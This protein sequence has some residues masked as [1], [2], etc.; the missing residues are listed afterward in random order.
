M[1]KNMDVDTYMGVN[2]DVNTYISNKREV[3]VVPEDRDM[4]NLPPHLCIL[5][6]LGPAQQKRRLHRCMGT[7]LTRKCLFLGPYSRPMPRALRW[8]SVGQQFLMSEVPL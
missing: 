3:E 2:M 7:S 8:S 1:G 4:Q 6:L 5:H